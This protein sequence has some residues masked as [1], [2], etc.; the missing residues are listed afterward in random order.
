[1]VIMLLW[2]LAFAN[3]FVI[4]LIS[5]TFV[6]IHKLLLPIDSWKEKLV[7]SVVIGLLTPYKEIQG[8]AQGPCD[9]YDCKPFVWFI[10][11]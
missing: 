5:L 3:N 8:H 9:F 1:M 11:V 4:L 6:Q 7:S 10:S 2:S